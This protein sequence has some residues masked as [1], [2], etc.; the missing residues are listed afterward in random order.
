MTYSLSR[1]ACFIFNCQSVSFL[2]WLSDWIYNT[3]LFDKKRSL[4]NLLHT[5][6]WSPTGNFWQNF[7]RWSSCWYRT[8]NFNGFWF[9]VL[10]EFR[11]KRMPHTV[12]EIVGNDQ[13]LH[14]KGFQFYSK[15]D[16][17]AHTP[18]AANFRCRFID[19]ELF[20]R[21]PVVKYVSE[22]TNFL[23][24]GK[25]HSLKSL[26]TLKLLCHKMRAPEPLPWNRTGILL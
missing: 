14:T 22:M 9:W 4:I 24:F 1:A 15:L 20:I 25:I 19:N 2:V 7:Y 8:A 6:L 13:H 10:N 17:R 18:R 16:F 21:K 26:I 11:P 5:N 12:C 3:K 23:F